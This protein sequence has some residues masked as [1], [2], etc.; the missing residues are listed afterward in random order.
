MS[1]ADSGR[2]DRPTNRC[3]SPVEH[4]GVSTLVSQQ[5]EATTS[6]LAV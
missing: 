6:R 1:L 2:Y 5:F 4:A 3:E